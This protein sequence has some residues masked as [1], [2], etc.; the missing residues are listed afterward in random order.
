MSNLSTKNIKTGGDGGM[1]KTLEPGTNLCKINNVTLE[2]FTFKEGA[3]N[4]M[5]HLE[6]EDLGDDFQGF[7][8]DKNNES[9]GRHKG[10]VG[11]VKATEWAFAD[12]ETKSGIA[13][14]RDS[15][16][17]KFLK[18]LCTSFDCVKWFDAQ[19]DKHPTIESIY[20]AFNKEKPFKD[21]FFRFCIAGKEYTNRGG[22][23]AHELFLPK[24]S[25]DGTPIEKDDVQVSKLIKYNEANHIRKK[26]EEK[27][28]GFGDSKAG[29]DF[30]L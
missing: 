29:S 3:L 15:E 24:Y 21:Q 9:L 18:Q 12:G 26:K 17:M 1:S 19:D 14:S 23:K 13:V 25:K 8:I 4:V 28:E 10:K 6:G 30:E 7:F 27:V 22:Y 16:M 2:E 20:T 11:V 5:F